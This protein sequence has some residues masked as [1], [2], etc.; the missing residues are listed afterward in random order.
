MHVAKW[1]QQDWT[2]GIDQSC[3]SLNCRFRSH[4]SSAPHIREVQYRNRT[5]SL[6]LVDMGMIGLDLIKDGWFMEKG[7]LWPGQA[8]SLEVEEVLH[9]CMSKFQDILV[10][11]S[12]S[13]GKVFVL[14]GVIQFTERDEFAYQEMIA[15]L[16]LF[17]HPNPKSVLVVG[18]GD[19]GVLR[20]VLK[21]PTV[22]KAVL[23]EI[24]EK[25]IEVSKTYFPAMASSFKDDRVKVNIMDGAKYMEEHQG[26]YDVIITDSS[27]PIGPAKALF[28]LP[29][30]E[31]M[32]G[33]L[34][35][36]GVICTQGECMWLH[37]DLIQ[38]LMAACKR[39][40]PIVEYGYTTIPTYPSGQIGFILCGK[41]RNGSF[42]EP[43]RKPSAEMMDTLRYYNPSIHTAAFV[44]PTFAS[45]AMER[46]L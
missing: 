8:M 37:L 32:H 12:K 14:D 11:K 10:F 5:R 39:I 34:N 36:G 23:C 6:I 44:L 27:D 35:D 45:K 4:F 9:H 3:R 26:E 28:E 43:I 24:D 29:F 30:Y 22:E 42:R 16:P 1:T 41:G 13:Y 21:H 17:S 31:A 38:P 46:S 7:E 20:E 25:V 18:G 15:H 33:C 19:G 2:R 40:F